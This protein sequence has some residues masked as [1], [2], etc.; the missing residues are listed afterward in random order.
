MINYIPYAAR[1]YLR[2]RFFNSYPTK[3]ILNLMVPEIGI[4]IVKTMQ[5]AGIQS[6]TFAVFFFLLNQIQFYEENHKVSFQTLFFTC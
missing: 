4:K 2:A 6:F 1:V 5:M 3:I